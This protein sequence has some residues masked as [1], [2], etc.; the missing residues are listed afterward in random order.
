MTVRAEPFGTKLLHGRGGLCWVH[1]QPLVVMDAALATVDRI[2]LLAA[3]LAQFELDEL[4][5]APAVRALIDA[6]REGQRVLDVGRA[7]SSPPSAA[8]PGLARTRPK[9]T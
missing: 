1:G 7:D 6:A 2:P 5:V 4:Q 3:A 8:K 9:A